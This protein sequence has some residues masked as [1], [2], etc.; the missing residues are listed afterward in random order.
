[1]LSTVL[2]AGAASGIDLGR[3]LLELALILCTAKV[4]AEFAERVGVPA[5]LGEILA[6]VVIGPSLLGLVEPSDS[7]FLLGELGAILL[8]MQVGMEIDVG[9][10]RNV[11]RSALT[12]AIIGVTLPLT[13]GSFTGLALGE[14]GN[15]ALFIGATLTATSVGIT[16]RVFGDLRALSTK[17]AR[18]VLGA[19]VAD[20]VL[21]L[22]ILTIVTRIVE[23]GTIGIG[24]IATTSLTAF[25]F[26]AVA[27][28]VGF[29]AVPRLIGYV[30]KKAA[31]PAAVS[32]FAVG[33]A[34]AYSGVADA[35][36]LAPIIGAFVAGAALGKAP[37][38]ERIARDVSAVAALF[39][40]VFFLQI[41]IETDVASMVRPS[42]LAIAA[43]LI[44]V[45]VVTKVVAGW[46]AG[47]NGGDKLLVGLG[48]MP[49]GEVGLI[50]ATIGMGVG[51]FDDDLHAALV[52]VVLATT[53]ISPAALRWRINSKGPAEV[54][55][56]V[57]ADSEPDG[58]WLRVESGR[59]ALAANPPTSAAP[60]VLLSAAL[61]A[62]EHK[63]S[64][65]LL[66]WI[67]ERRTRDLVWNR[68][69]TT[70]LLEVLRGGTPR[71]WR[72]LEIAGL[73][74]RT[75]PEIANAIKER[76]SDVS[77]LDPTNIL[78]FPTVETLR[79]A[80]AVATSQSD[81]LLLAAFLADVDAG[82]DTTASI[83]QRLD[84]DL[85][86]AGEV[87]DLLNGARIL[88]AAVEHEPHRVDDKMLRDIAHGLRRPG[89]VERSRLLA[90]AIGGLEPWQHAAMIDITIGVQSLLAHP[91]LL[92][93]VD[94]SLAD[95][96]RR[97]AKSLTDDPALVDRI[98]HSP[99]TYVLAHEPAMLLEHAR[100]I[101]PAPH[102]RKVRVTVQP[103]ALAGQWMINV[104]CRNRRG[105]L[106]RLSGAL[107]DAGHSVV[108]ASLAT[109]PDDSV[110]DTFVVT[111]DNPPDPT[112]LSDL[113][114]RTLRGR[115]KA[116]RIA[117]EPPRIAI[118]NSIHPWHSVLRVGG[119]DRIGLLA[120]ISYALS[121]IGVVV[122][123]A[124]VQT[125]DGLVDDN[126]EIS[127]RVGRKVPEHAADRVIRI[128]KKL[129]D[130]TQI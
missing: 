55:L 33:I 13:I 62:R 113:L 116:R 35:A 99:T 40:P 114:G 11:G 121:E 101:E 15:T 96:R 47:R 43:A 48:M 97:Q 122:H 42:V 94:D 52:L 112:R 8:L 1:M 67:A 104:A 29:T 124:V 28:A 56:D 98:T 83:L 84:V 86:I 9:E 34:L 64:D 71:S 89:I 87:E 68:D 81:T 17:E 7:L 39:V 19:A 65:E 51:V 73:F 127:D 27:S 80:T 70:R 60:N 108:S 102:G 85:L 36:K 77:E 18:I 46:G 45:A 128:L 69:A 105:L 21:G 95:M 75:I 5:V 120:A 4:V 72:L 44:A 25:S 78:R 117:G 6:G 126:F 37:A 58:G 82:T 63:P 22:I 106:S 79:E 61:L 41:G 115:L 24:T 66:D 49:R 118:D 26:L 111:A 3:I 130:E 88:R 119:P 14:S 54:D 50:F 107:A 31:S 92:E 76:A 53:V 2:A 129:S 59:I 57:D 109:W 74:E 100:L 23:E 125:R 16:A 32:V 20:D 12:V 93:G 90:D 103:T 110:L 30:A 91:E 38:H 123:H 10:L